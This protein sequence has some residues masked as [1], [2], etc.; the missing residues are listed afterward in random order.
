MASYRYGGL[1]NAISIPKKTDLGP[2][3]CFDPISNEES[4]GSMNSPQVFRFKRVLCLFFLFL[5]IRSISFAVTALPTGFV[6]SEFVTGLS[7]PTAM[8]FAPDG[9]LFVCEQAGKLR[10][11]KNGQ[12]LTPPFLSVTVN[13]S[14]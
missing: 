9:R 2:K 13:S 3:L 14:G 8:A 1:S 12:L 6:E 4:L 5:F 7:N 11:I 10:V